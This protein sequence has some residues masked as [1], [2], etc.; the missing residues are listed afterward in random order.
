MARPAAK[1]GAVKCIKFLPSG[2]QI[3]IVVG[4]DYEYWTDTDIGFCS[5][6]DYY[7]STLRGGSECY[8]MKSVRRAQ[9]NN[10]EYTKLEFADEDYAGFVGAIASDA[11]RLLRD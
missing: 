8:H 7:F 2:R 4:K 5:C 10:L 6:A 3:W 9:E 1:A 11:E